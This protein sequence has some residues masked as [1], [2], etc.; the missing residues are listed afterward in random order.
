MSGARAELLARPET[1]FA[2]ILTAAA[3]AFTLGLKSDSLGASEA[4]SA[5]AA[6]LATPR[7][8]WNIPVLHDPGKQVFY[9]ILLHFWSGVFGLS[10]VALRSLSVIFALAELLLVFAV[11]RE[12]FDDQT[13]L[14]AAAV[15]AFN[16]ISVV[17]AHRA[18]MYS[19]F[20]AIGLAQLL[21][22]WRTR[23]RATAFRVASCGVLGAMLIYTH[24]GGLVI[25]GVE[26]ALL[27]RDSSRGSRAPGPWLALGVAALLWLP[28]LP[29]A[30]AQSHTLVSGHWLD[31]IAPDHH[32]PIA[33]KL[34][35][36]VAALAVSA[37]LVFGPLPADTND[38]PLRWCAAWSLIPAIAFVAGSVAIRPIFHIRYVAPSAAVLVIGLVHLLGGL[39]ART[40]NLVTVAIASALL[41][42][43]P[44]LQPIPQHW[45]QIAD[46]VAASG[47][48]EPVFL[49]DGFVTS[50]EALHAANGGFPFGY[51]SIPFDYYAHSPNPRVIIPAHDPAAARNTIE[52][53]VSQAGG[54][55]L[56]SWENER[57]ARP[58]LPDPARY[59]ISIVLRGE[60]LIV[61]RITP[62]ER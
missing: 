55:W 58:E 15:W 14:A 20:I 10:V 19:M 26:A 62:L 45:D 17:F 21:M 33:L 1:L 30:N 22:M 60:Q 2:A 4:Y 54:G 61:Y 34:G 50:G 44:E 27:L 29:I 8:I 24:L 32:Y 35:A 43:S 37:W 28:W 46:M 11:G 56:L 12:M 7:A 31:W 6:A 3:I 49:E 16:P 23:E 42:A 18:R 51:Y 38:E 47:P 59:R 40:R 53:R 5:M 52:S 39:G 48:S 57:E 36:A 9:Y 41:L 13:G 25:L